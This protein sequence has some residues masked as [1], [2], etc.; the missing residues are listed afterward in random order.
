MAEKAVEATWSFL[1][2]VGRLWPILAG[3]IMLVGYCYTLDARVTDLQN[4]INTMLS[5]NIAARVQI[6]ENDRANDSTNTISQSQSIE[7]QF[8]TL[9][10]KETE[11][12]NA[13][14]LL[15][16]QYAQQSAQITFLIQK[17]YPGT[18]T[19]P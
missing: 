11:I 17:D 19:G 2:A 13:L 6:L 1:D 4:T 3:G 10:A 9:S 16:Q 18:R 5:H 12:G 7:N 15:S 8:A 14:A